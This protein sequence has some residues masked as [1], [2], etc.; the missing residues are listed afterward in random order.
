METMQ[1]TIKAS[2]GSEE[3]NYKKI[4]RGYFLFGCHGNDVAYMCYE[5]SYESEEVN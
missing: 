1:Y 4:A 2:Y 3:I 5:L